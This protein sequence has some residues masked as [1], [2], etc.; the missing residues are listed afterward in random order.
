MKDSILWE[1]PDAGA[2]EGCEKEGVAE[3]KHYE[4]TAAPFSILL[5]C[6]IR[7]R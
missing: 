3:R 2:G 6:M 4:L 7:G 5:G 1:Q